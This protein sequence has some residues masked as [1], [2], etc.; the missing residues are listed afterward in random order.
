MFAGNKLEDE[1]TLSNYNIE[2][3]TTLYLVERFRGG[4]G[5]IFVNTMIGE[6][7]R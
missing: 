1:C 5:A 3:E 4:A 7:L 2:K 6:S